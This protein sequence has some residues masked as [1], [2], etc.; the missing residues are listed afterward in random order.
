MTTLSATKKALVPLA[1][2][3]AL[4]GTVIASA[5]PAEAGWYYHRYGH[6]YGGAVA[7]GIIGGLALG[8]IAAAAASPPVY[9]APVVAAPVSCTIVR[10]QFVDRYGRL[11][12]RHTQVC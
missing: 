8:A 9:A 3:L 4:G 10:R 5:A 1:A 6:G 7:A 12:T 11:V 2:A